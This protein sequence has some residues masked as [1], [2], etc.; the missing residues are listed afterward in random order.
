[1]SK[2]K[3]DQTIRVGN[4]YQARDINSKRFKGISKFPSLCKASVPLWDADDII[5][6][7]EIDDFNIVDQN[8][9]GKASFFLVF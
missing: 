5:I 4:A 3:E 6:N 7:D 1:M 2:S 8:G 9:T